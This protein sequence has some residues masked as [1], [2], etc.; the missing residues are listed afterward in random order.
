MCLGHARSSLLLDSGAIA[1]L[2]IRTNSPMTAIQQPT[3]TS[4]QPRYNPRMDSE[5]G[6]SATPRLIA[7]QPDVQP[8]QFSLTE[9]GCTLGRASTC[10]IVV[11]RSL[12]S[13]LHARI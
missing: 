3:T 9:D 10:D 5:P 13:R 1:M 6:L 2:R 7:L 4:R 11:P 12:V 8:A